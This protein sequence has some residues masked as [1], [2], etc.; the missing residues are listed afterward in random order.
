VRAD[1]RERNCPKC[2]RPMTAT[3]SGWRCQYCGYWEP[4][5]PPAAAS[6]AECLAAQLLRAHDRLRAAFPTARAYEIPSAALALEWWRAAR[7]PT[8]WWRPRPKAGSFREGE[9]HPPEGRLVDRSAE[10]GT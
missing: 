8:P 10:A 5:S 4:V 6:A 3:L 9:G 1:A 2:G 7:R